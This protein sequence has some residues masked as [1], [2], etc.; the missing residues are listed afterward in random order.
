MEQCQVKFGCLEET[1]WAIL[2]GQVVFF[3]MWGQGSTKLKTSWQHRFQ[4]PKFPAETRDFD[5]EYEQ[6]FFT[7]Q[8]LM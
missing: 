6:H 5:F 1:Q 8:L 4:D 3:G 2:G 7:L